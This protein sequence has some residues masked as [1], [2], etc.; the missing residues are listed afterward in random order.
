M[1]PSLHKTLSTVLASLLTSNS[2]GHVAVAYSSLHCQQ[3]GSVPGFAGPLETC[4]DRNTS[5]GEFCT[6]RDQRGLSYRDI[7]SHRKNST[8]FGTWSG[9]VCQQHA[10]Y[11]FV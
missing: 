7:V 6:S 2:R 4:L 10:E 5:Q 8:S 1:I 3:A 9:M 11:F